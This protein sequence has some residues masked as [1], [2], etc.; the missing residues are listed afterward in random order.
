MIMIYPLS[1][2]DPD[3]PSRPADWRWQRACAPSQGRATHDPPWHQ[4]GAD[5]LGGDAWLA[6]AVRFVGL[7]HRDPAGAAQAM[8][9][10]GGAFGIFSLRGPLCRGEVEARLLTTEPLGS[11]AA[12]CD[13]TA[14]VVEA[15]HAVFYD[16]RGRLDARPDLDRAPLGPP[17]P[18]RPARPPGDH[19]PP[20]VSPVLLRRD[21]FS[22]DLLRRLG[23]GELDQVRRG[24]AAKAAVLDRLLAG[25]SEQDGP[26]WFLRM[27]G[28]GLQTSRG[29]GVAAQIGLAAN[30]L[31]NIDRMVLRPP[32]AAGEA[33]R[34]RVEVI[35]DPPSLD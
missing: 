26:R 21:P 5:G 15:Y 20:D 10:I 18:G 14:E 33:G 7:L 8:P 2:I 30:L 22:D 28:G 11:I 19:P 4:N 27:A 6:R 17:P 34:P 24:L 12:A 9:N 1:W 29:P 32:A 16:V 35:P 13:T 25:R 31:Q 3:N 23:P